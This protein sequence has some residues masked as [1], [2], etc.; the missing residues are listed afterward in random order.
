[1]KEHLLSELGILPEPALAAL[2]RRWIETA[3]QLLG[4]AATPEG[5]AGLQRLLACDGPALDAWIAQVEK[6]VGAAP[7]AE[8]A[9]PV[10]ARKLGLI[11]PK[12]PRP[13]A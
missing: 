7:S 11:V 8:L 4:T 9:H 3:E 10:P 1:M 13:E 6:V 5:R 2:Q 12:E